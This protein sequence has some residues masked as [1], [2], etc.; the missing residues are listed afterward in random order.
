VTFGTWGA[1]YVVAG[2]LVADDVLPATG[3]PFTLE[4]LVNTTMCYMFLQIN[5]HVL[6]ILVKLPNMELQ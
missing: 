2:V 4:I 1:R 3:S 6:Y 5:I